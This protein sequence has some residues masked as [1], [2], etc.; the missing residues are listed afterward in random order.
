MTKHWQRYVTS[1]SKAYQAV[2]EKR[3]TIS[4]INKSSFLA[5]RTD[6]ILRPPDLP[7]P[8]TIQ[9]QETFTRL[10]SLKQRK[11]HSNISKEESKAI[12]SLKKNKDIIIKQADKGSGITVM[13]TAQY[14]Q[15]GYNHL[16]DETIYE[17]TDFDY[18]IQLTARINL[19]LKEMAKT[20]EI[21]QDLYQTLRL[22]PEVVKIQ[23]L[24]FLRKLHKTPHAIRPIVSATGGPTEVISAYMDRILSPYIQRC[25]HVIKSST[26]VIRRLQQQQFAPSAI[27]ATLDVKRLY[28][29]IPQAQGTEVVLNRL[30]NS[31]IPPKFKRASLEKLLVFILKDNFFSFTNRIYRQKSGVAM[32]TRCA[33]NFAN[34]FMVS[35]EEEFL[36]KETRTG[37]PVPSLWLRYIDDI[38]II[39]E[40]EQQTL[41]QFVQQLNELHEDIKFTLD[42]SFTSIN[43]LD[44]NIYKG[45]KFLQHKQLHFQ[46]YRKKCHKN[47][48]LRHDSCH[49]TNIFKSIVRGEAIRTLRNS[50][51]VSTYLIH[52]TRLFQSFRQRGYPLKRLQIWTKDLLYCN[53]DAWIWSKPKAPFRVRA[54]DTFFRAT[55][56]PGHS[57]SSI[58][59]ALAS[60][61][62]PFRNRVV[63]LPDKSLSKQLVRAA[64]PQQ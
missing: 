15:E 1:C 4:L 14:V 31:D 39:W 55:H 44:I 18:S 56:H 33:P 63:A 41:Q 24:Y 5:K 11:F 3:P 2:L 57:L 45:N 23:R 51:D 30:Y 17:R 32:G 26:E 52:L 36:Q 21:S 53:R 50:S 10:N 40:H 22:N 54:E 8:I 20:K 49:P 13:D 19:H 29:K 7:V 9:V 6:T 12:T 64:V 48:Y 16:Q 38:I 37:R 62:L 28:L 61:L 58:K 34:L 46:P 47:S 42:W 60:D 35:L 25:H 27:L 43:F 59:R